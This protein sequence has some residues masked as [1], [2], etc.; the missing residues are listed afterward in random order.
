MAKKWVVDLTDDERSQLEA[1]TRR[2]VA[3]VR[4]VAHARVLLLAD[5][6]QTDAE[7]VQ[8]TSR[9]ASFVE[10]TR[11][12]FVQNG[13]DDALH[14]RPRPGAATKLDDRGR[15]TLLAVT[16]SPAP[17]GATRWTLQLLADELV[18]REVVPAI[19]YETIRRELKKV[20]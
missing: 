16:C 14:D 18:Q 5:A 7:I 19:S 12:R 6:G 10:R 2:G 9:S 1:L 15:A 4:S 3:P 11:R 13:L 8:H 20:I 17:Q